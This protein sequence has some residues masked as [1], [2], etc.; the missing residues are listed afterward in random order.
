MVLSLFLSFSIITSALFRLS[1]WAVFRKRM[2]GLT[3]NR[4]SST[5]TPPILARAW[6][7]QD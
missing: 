1:E 5:L 2:D 4:T 6:S 7:R 3:H